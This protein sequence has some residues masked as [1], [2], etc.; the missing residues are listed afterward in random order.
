MGRHN[1]RGSAPPSPATR[2]LRGGKSY[3]C[4]QQRE[5]R[6]KEGPS[7][8]WGLRER[9]TKKSLAALESKKYEKNP[10]LKGRKDGAQNQIGTG[11]KVDREVT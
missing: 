8:R 6:K 1:V 4:T 7:L 9:G 3:K 5:G 2:L 10:Q 11:D